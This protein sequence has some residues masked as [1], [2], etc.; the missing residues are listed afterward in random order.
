MLCRLKASHFKKTLKINRVHPPTRK[1]RA[2]IGVER[3]LSCQPLLFL[4]SEIQQ[5]V[6]VWQNGMLPDT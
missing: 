5:V 2:D 1:V 3:F 6:W 4:A